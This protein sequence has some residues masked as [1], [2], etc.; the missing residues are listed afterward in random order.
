MKQSPFD[1]SKYTISG[2]PALWLFL[3]FLCNLSLTLY[4]KGVLINF[5]FPYTLTTIHALS[6]TF[7]TALLARAGAF[8]PLRLS[9]RQ[10]NT[11]IAFSFLYT[12]NIAVSNLSLQKVTVPFHQVIRAA[13][14]FFTIALSST[15]L[16]RKC[17]RA[18]LLFLLPTVAGVALAT[19]GDYYFT[20]AGFFLTLLGTFLAALKTLMTEVLQ[21]SPRN[22]NE[23]PM[24][25]T[26]NI[27]PMYLPRTPPTSYCLVSTNESDQPWVQKSSNNAYIRCI[28]KVALE[29]WDPDHLQ[30][31]SMA[32]V[33]QPPEQHSI[34][35][36]SSSTLDLNISGF[37][38]P[39]PRSSPIALLHVLAPFAAFQCLFLTYLTGE[40]AKVRLYFLPPP[41]AFIPTPMFTTPICSNFLMVLTQFSHAVHKEQ[42]ALL[43]LNGALAF[44]LNVVSFGAN[45]RV[46]AVGMTVA[47]NIKQVLTILLA[48]SV[49]DLTITKMNAAGIV[50]T[51]IGGAL[52]AR[53]EL[54]EKSNKERRSM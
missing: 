32:V 53:V 46:G 48:V 35:S 45:K 33:K 37:F 9:W 52:Y 34:L 31:T 40:S 10:L 44:A 24:G 3:Y 22:K 50:L 6:G 26:E 54:G 12:I 49:F 4:N 39:L 16:E 13:T 42:V 7:G 20:I 14:P 47:A 5:P 21:T 41:S 29:H 8:Q 28:R 43:A 36:F 11:V 18:K 27:L 19:C 25:I 17:S 15:L 30:T 1:W 38:M 2:S 23:P 51:L